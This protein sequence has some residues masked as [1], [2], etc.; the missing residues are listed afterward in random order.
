MENIEWKLLK[1][2][3][4]PKRGIYKVF[5]YDYDK[6]ESAYLLWDSRHGFQPLNFGEPESYPINMNVTHWLKIQEPELPK[7]EAKKLLVTTEI[8]FMG[9]GL[10]LFAK[11]N[12]ISVFQRCGNAIE[13]VTTGVGDS[14]MQ[15]MRQ[16]FKSNGTHKNI[17]WFK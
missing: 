1:E 14:I 10:E 15:R 3:R 13:Y 16:F 7:E 2:E 4:P 9:N 12:N 6:F 5:H 17:W 8:F 11:E